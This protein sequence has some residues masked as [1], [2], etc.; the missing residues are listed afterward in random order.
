MF[1]RATSAKAGI[2][3]RAMNHYTLHIIVKVGLGRSVTN[4]TLL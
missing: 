1:R 3:T 4:P 2:A